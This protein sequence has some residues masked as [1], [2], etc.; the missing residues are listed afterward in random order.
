MTDTPGASGTP[1]PAPR[2][3][4]RG[5]PA[6]TDAD[7]GPGARERILAAAR[8]EFAGHGYDKASIRG[9]AK[10]AGV[11]PALVHHYFGPKEKIFAAAVET[12][13][14]PALGAAD[15]LVEG[16][17]EDLG[18]RLARFVLGVWEAPATREPVLAV[19]RSAM[20]NETAAAVFRD[21]ISTRIMARVAGQLEGPDPRLRSELAAAHL[22]GVAMLRHVMRIEPLASADLEQVIAM[23]APAVQ[24]HLTGG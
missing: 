13:F 21:L 8:A 2:A 12:A 5:R 24:R 22:V 9:M 4:K 10:A 3:R 18:E 17:P 6:R 14:T 1:G 11:D 7:G 15:V 20:A 16:G 23:T 19:L